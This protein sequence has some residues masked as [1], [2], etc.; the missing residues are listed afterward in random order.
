MTTVTTI[1]PYTEQKI[2]T[3]SLMTKADAEE[4]I[5][6][7]HTCFQSWKLT[8]FD[9]RATLMQAL[10]DEIEE[11]E[12]ALVNLMVSEMGKLAAQAKQEIALCAAICRYSADNAADVLADEEREFEQGKALITHQPIGVILGIQPWNFPLYQVIR[13]S[14][15]NIMAGNVT[16][17]KHASNVFGMSQM[18]ETLYRKAGFPEHC[19]QSLL[20]DGETVNDLIANQYIRGVTFTGSDEIGKKVGAEAARYAKKSVLELGS[21]DAFMV[22]DDADI[23]LAVEACVKGRMIN[24]GE[25]CV[26]AKRFIV[27]RKNYA[28]FK[29]QF[30][31]ALEDMKMGD[32]TAEDTD[33]G[34]MAREDLRDELHEQVTQSIQKGAVNVIGCE[35]PERTGF[36]YPPSILENVKPGMPAYDDELFGPVAALIEAQD[37]EDAMRIAN[38]SRYGL[39]GGIFS[40][41]VDKAIELAKL[42]FDTGMVN[43][44]GYALAQP[45]LPFGGVKASGYGREHGGLGMTEFVNTKSIMIMPS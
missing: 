23:A 12:D 10:A 38:D 29:Q 31:A 26:S 44:N 33:L 3:Y 32:P 34:P 5:E 45:N 16:V 22:L 36:F 1:N 9:E 42:H 17:L 14:A 15:A 11:A 41:N 20:L 25:T 21:N 35:V 39:G 24:N 6:Q 40:K 28:A 27:T 2:T 43:I 37:D 19:Y 7:A 18:I 4:R 13:Y 8:S 30:V